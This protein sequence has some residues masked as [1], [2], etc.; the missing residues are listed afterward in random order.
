[1]WAKP[2]FLNSSDRATYA[3]LT[4][5]TVYSFGKALITDA[6]AATTPE[7]Y[8]NIKFNILGRM[9]LLY[10]K[11]IPIIA[12]IS[13]IVLIMIYKCGKKLRLL[14]SG[15]KYYKKHFPHSP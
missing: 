7:K 11:L 4:H 13:F 15:I 1:M 5:C 10:T 3:L 2:Y 9:K 8:Q 6:L 14:F 12:I